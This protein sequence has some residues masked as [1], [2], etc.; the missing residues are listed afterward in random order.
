MILVCGSTVGLD[1]PA[2]LCATSGGWA[3]VRTCFDIRLT[4]LQ[5]WSLYFNLGRQSWQSILD[6]SWRRRVGL[7]FMFRLLQVDPMAYP[8]SCVSWAYFEKPA[9]GII[10]LPRT[11]PWSTIWVSGRK[12]DHTRTWICSIDVLDRWI[13]TFVSARTSVRPTSSICR[14]QDHQSRVSA[15]PCVLDWS[16]V[17]CWYGAIKMFN[18]STLRHILSHI[19]Q[20]GFR[21]S[22]Q[23]GAH[24][25]SANQHHMHHIIAL[26]IARQPW[27]KLL[28]RIPRAQWHMPIWNWS[29]NF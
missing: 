16:W 12:S 8:V 27:G 3:Q 22:L 14:F 10:E 9:N 15:P 26:R 19:Y 23:C 28:I 11:I 6:S 1:A 4:L 24:E 2:L 25:A 13:E 7:R 17:N 18:L 29:Y 20:F 21:R 5:D